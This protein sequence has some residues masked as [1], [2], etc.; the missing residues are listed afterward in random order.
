MKDD[1]SVDCEQS[2]TLIPIIVG[3][4]ISAVI[5]IA[6]IVALFIIVNHFKTDEQKAARKVR[7][8]ENAVKN[9]KDNNAK[10][11]F[12]SKSALVPQPRQAGPDPA[13]LASLNISTEGGGMNMEDDE[14]E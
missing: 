3:G 9:A 12:D 6:A 7:Q 11:T 8:S 14:A 10:I 13:L 2:N 4:A 5:I 1:K